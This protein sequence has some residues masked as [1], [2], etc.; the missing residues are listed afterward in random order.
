MYSKVK[1][2]ECSGIRAR[3]ET[4]GEGDQYAMSGTGNGGKA[5]GT[6]RCLSV[7]SMGGRISVRFRE[8]MYGYFGVVLPSSDQSQQVR[9]M[10]RG[11]P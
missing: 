2:K 10:T 7:R 9:K 6:R 5:A 4:S 1:R 3:R 11:A 8:H